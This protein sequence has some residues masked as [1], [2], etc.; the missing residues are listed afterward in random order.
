[1]H[2]TTDE[3]RKDPRNAANAVPGPF[4]NDG[5][6]TEAKFL[7]EQKPAGCGRIDPDAKN[8]GDDPRGWEVVKDEDLPKNW[9]WRYFTNPADGKVYN[10]MSWTTN[11]HIPTYCGSCWAQASTSALADRFNIMNIK[12]GVHA[13]RAPVALAPQ[14]MVNCIF[15]SNCNGGSANFVYEYAMEHGIPH[16]SCLQYVSENNSCDALNTCRDC[17]PPIPNTG[18]D[19]TANC[20]AVTDYTK[21]YASSTTVFSGAADMKKEIFAHGPIA[22]GQDATHKFL[23]T[24]TGGIYSEK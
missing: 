6:S 2:T 11:Q 21:Y 20:K 14:A 24:Y 16:A 9:D 18:E 4:P 12:S 13:D 10:P 23:N 15:E 17:V 7:E 19:L 8:H 3:D 5:W 1:M 22:C